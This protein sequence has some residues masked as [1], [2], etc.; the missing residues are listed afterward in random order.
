MLGPYDVTV[1]TVV[2]SPPLAQVL[3]FCAADPVERVFLEDVARRGLG[4]GVAVGGRRPPPGAPGPAPPQ[5]VF[6]LDAPPPRAGPG[7]RPAPRDE[8]ELLVPACAAAYLE[9]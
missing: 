4:G 1:P 8:L 9:E 2:E 3:E 6:V 7:L 5:P